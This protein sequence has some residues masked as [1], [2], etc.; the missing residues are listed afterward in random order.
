M[1][2]NEFLQDLKESKDE[3][4]GCIMVK[5]ED[6]DNVKIILEDNNIHASFVEPEVPLIFNI[7]RDKA[8]DI[9]ISNHELLEEIDEFNIPEFTNGI[10]NGVIWQLE[11]ECSI[12]KIDYVKAF[13]TGLEFSSIETNKGVED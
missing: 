3:K 13:K 5:E 4:W 10:M 1:N 12:D 9:A 2:K 7:A 8:Y 6:I 11:T